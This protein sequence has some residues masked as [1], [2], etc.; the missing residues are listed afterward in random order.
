MD[1]RKQRGLSNEVPYF[2]P[3]DGGIRAHAL[4]L[5]EAPGPK[6]RVSGFISRDNPDPTARNFRALLH[7]ADIP[8]EKTV[9]W[10]IVPWYIGTGTTIR[11][12]TS[13]DIRTGTTHLEDLLAL[14]PRVRLVVLVGRKAQRVR[15]AVQALTNAEIVET[16]HPSN[17]VVVCWPDKRKQL[18]RD[19]RAVSSFLSQ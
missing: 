18:L 4:F 17:Q 19:L 10:N 5:L 1:L 13:N 8:R 14:L 6:A 3:C 15:G 7:E 12:A 2:D 16:L 11:A 9:L